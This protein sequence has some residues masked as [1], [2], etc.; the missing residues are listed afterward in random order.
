MAGTKS[1][2]QAGRSLR[3]VSLAPP[4]AKNN[5]T[6]GNSDETDWEK[7]PLHSATVQHATEKSLK[8]A[9]GRVSDTAALPTYQLPS[10]VDLHRWP[11]SYRFWNSSSWTW[12]TLFGP[13]TS[14]T[15]GGQWVLDRKGEEG[16]SYNDVSSILSHIADRNIAIGAASRGSREDVAL[17]M[18]FLLAIPGVIGRT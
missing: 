4:P 18:L 2:V 9:I 3:L 1:M 14:I 7:L 6:K 13:L 15:Q 11:T 10:P 17:Q 8:T 12:T 16:G 5:V